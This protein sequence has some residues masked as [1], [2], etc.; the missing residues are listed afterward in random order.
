[1]NISYAA[2]AWHPNENLLAIASPMDVQ[3][4]D[5]AM[6]APITT[7]DQE[8][9]IRLAWSPDGKYLAGALLDGTIHIWETPSF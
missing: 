1:D 5:P 4:F 9:V 6:D 3:I 2:I 8:S 7:I